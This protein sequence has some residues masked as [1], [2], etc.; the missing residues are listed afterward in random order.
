MDIGHN[1]ICY[2]SNFATKDGITVLNMHVIII[3]NKVPSKFMY[4]LTPH[5]YKY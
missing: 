1:L 4:V 2:S 3:V 5:T